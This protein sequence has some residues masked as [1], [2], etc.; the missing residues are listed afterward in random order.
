M[1]TDLLK[2]AVSFVSLCLAAWLF[3][4]RMQVQSLPHTTPTQSWQAP[5][6]CPHPPTRTATASSSHTR[7]STQVCLPYVYFVCASHLHQFQ[8]CRPGHQPRLSLPGLA[9]TASAAEIQRALAA[10]WQ[11]HSTP[12][13]SRARPTSSASSASQAGL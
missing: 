11:E 3:H 8:V 12:G 4:T 2:L 5:P 13:S 1:W 6:T 7:P 9:P 10:G